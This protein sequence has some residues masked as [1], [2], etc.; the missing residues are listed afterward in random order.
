MKHFSAQQYAALKE[1]LGE[2][3]VGDFWINDDGDIDVPRGVMLQRTCYNIPHNLGIRFGT[4]SGCFD[5]SNTLI[6]SIQGFPKSIQGNLLC[7]R[8]NISSLSGI[9][10]IVKEVRGFIRV[11]NATTHLLGLL[12]VDGVSYV[13]TGRPAVNDILN[14]YVKSK[15]IISAQDELID[16]GFVDIAH[17]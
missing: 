2:F 17:L 12:M 14:K 9:D 10:R 8:S 11:G 5:V 4:V 3:G 1:R 6:T 15:D 16:R 13:E 7:H